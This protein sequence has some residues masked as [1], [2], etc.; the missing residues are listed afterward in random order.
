MG[1]SLASFAAFNSLIYFFMPPDEGK[2]SLF[3][4][5]FEQG[6]VLGLFTVIGLVSF[7]GRFL[8]GLLDPMVANWSD[9][10]RSKFGKRRSLMAVAAVPVALFS[11]LIFAPVLNENSW[12]NAVWL[13]AC[14]LVFYFFFTLY[15]VP[16]TALMSELGH[17]PRDRMRISTFLSV[18]WAVGFLIGSN[19]LFFQSLLEIQGL[20]SV[21]AF[22]MTVVGFAGLSLLAMLVPVFWLDEHQFAARSAT[23]FNL[24]KSLRTVFRN[25]DFLFF[26]CSDLCF[27][28]AFTFIQ[29]GLVFYITL[30]MGFDKTRAAVFLTIA[31]VGSFLLY[32]PVNWLVSRFGKK[33]VVLAAFWLFSVCFLGVSLLGSLPFSNETMFWGL[34]IGAAFPLSAFGIIPNAIVSDLIHAEEKRSGESLAAMFY[35]TRAFMMKVGVSLANLIFPSLLLLGKSVANPFGVRASAVLAV[36]FCLVGLVFFRKYGEAR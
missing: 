23:T 19:L 34:A 35:A 8:D 26:M 32:G 6:A 31:A 7:G 10:R 25:R 21:S 18:A 1:W 4:S 11:V 36:V 29:L 16:Y 5:F 13:A 27:W 33:R 15:T 17:D 20:S 22:Q 9:R 30:L 2:T 3:P 28:L 24:K 14:L 12:W